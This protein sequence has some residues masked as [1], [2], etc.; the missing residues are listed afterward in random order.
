M[1]TALVRTV[2][3]QG[4]ALA[5]VRG[6]MV[7]PGAS[8][9]GAAPSPVVSS[10]SCSSPLAS[11]ARQPMQLT[12]RGVRFG[13]GGGSRGGRGGG[14]TPH[15]GVSS[16]SASRAGGGRRSLWLSAAIARG[17]VAVDDEHKQS[18]TPTTTPGGPDSIDSIAA[19]KAAARAAAAAATG[20]A[21]S[22]GASSIQV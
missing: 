6:A 12:H 9:I 14:R 3:G 20:S 16:A 19:A 4:R 1:A 13:G 5:A 7:A 21:E 2:K 18:Q 10:S 15:W 17:S 8:Y 22:Y 11:L